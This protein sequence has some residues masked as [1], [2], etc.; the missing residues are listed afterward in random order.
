[1]SHFRARSVILLDGLRYF[2]LFAVSRHAEVIRQWK[3]LLHLDGRADGISVDD[4]ARELSVTKRTVWRDLAALQEVGFPLTDEKRDRKTI[5]RI[6]KLPLKALTDSGLSITEICSLYLGRELL[7][8]LTGTAFESGVNSILKKVDKALSPRTRAFLDELPSVVRVRH[9]PRKK[10]PAGYDETVAMLIEAS[11]RRRIAEMRYF[12]V[13]S[14]RL[15]DYVVHPY[16][17]QYSE[18]GLYLQAYVPEYDEVRW[19]AIE[20]IK[21]IVA[22]DKSYTHVKAVQSS[23]LDPSLGLGNGRPER[24]VL[25]FSA[26]VAPY[27]RERVWHKSQ[28]IEELR[29]GGVRLGL[30]VCVDWVLHGWILSW[31]PHVHVAAPSALAEEILVKLEEARESYVPKLD[32]ERTLS[33]VS[34]TARSL[35]LLEHRRSDRRRTASPS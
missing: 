31:G 11:T 1:M 22:T 5:W 16:G 20:R 2:I 14:N 18:G 10:A 8:A 27:V 13:S 17:V 19:F 26:R 29:D 12:S 30:K 23:D 35:P 15:K 6:M 24:V 21:K 33:V 25:E 7:R 32:F 28:Q 9:H 3:L 34:S 4:L